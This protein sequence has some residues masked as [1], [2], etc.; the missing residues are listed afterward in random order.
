MISGSYDR[1]PSSE[2]TD[3]DAKVFDQAA[4]RS[5]SSPLIARS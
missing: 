1:K 3:A 5:C 4:A 2:V